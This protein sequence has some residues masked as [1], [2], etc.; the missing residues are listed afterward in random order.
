M[1]E[2]NLPAADEA[3]TSDIVAVDWSTE[4]IRD[5][6]DAQRSADMAADVK[7]TPAPQRSRSLEDRRLDGR[8]ICGRAAGRHNT[9]R[10]KTG[11]N[12]TRRNTGTTEPSH[13]SPLHTSSDRYDGLG[14]IAI[15]QSD[16]AIADGAACAFLIT[17]AELW[18]TNHT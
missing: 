11:R 7:S 14:S 1:I 6:G 18:K 15:S 4:R 10:N 8:Q 17:S 2:S 5:V 13:C 12:N 16:D 9:H 3:R